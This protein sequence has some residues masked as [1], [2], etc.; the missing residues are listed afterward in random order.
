MEGWAWQAVSGS[1]E[2]SMKQAKSINIGTKK[3]VR[4]NDTS[5]LQVYSII[6]V[7][8]GPQEDLLYLHS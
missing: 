6:Y 7:F 2:G 8:G 3:V 4:H 1:H 5:K